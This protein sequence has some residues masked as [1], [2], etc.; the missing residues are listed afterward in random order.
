[1]G[2]GHEKL[3]VYQL[4]IPYVEWVYEKA[5]SLNPISIWI[6]IAISIAMK[7][8]SLKKRNTTKTGIDRHVLSECRNYTKT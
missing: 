1:M 8:R 2:L 4:S 7:A 5:A 6:S 3:D